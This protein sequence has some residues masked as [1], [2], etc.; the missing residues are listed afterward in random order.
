MGRRLQTAL[1]QEQVPWGVLSHSNVQGFAQVR[2][3]RRPIASYIG[4]HPVYLRTWYMRDICM[5]IFISSSP[6]PV[7]RFSSSP[8]SFSFFHDRQMMLYTLSP[9]SFLLLPCPAF[10]LSPILGPVWL[11][12]PT[13]FF[14][15]VLRLLGPLL[16]LLLVHLELT[17]HERTGLYAL[18]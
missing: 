13:P 8:Y 5:N 7:S 4:T 12:L 16:S 2:P 15:L 14:S 17:T 11:Q 3:I 18:S 10:V 9:P 1:A 6:L